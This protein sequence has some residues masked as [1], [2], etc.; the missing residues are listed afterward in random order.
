MEEKWGVKT[1]KRFQRADWSR[2]PLTEDQL[3]YASLDTHYLLPLRD[4]LLAELKSKERVE[5]AREEFARLAQSDGAAQ[6]F[7]QDGFWRI[8][9][10]RDLAPREIAVLRELYLYRDQAAR[11]ADRPPFKVLGDNALLA[12]AQTQPRRARDMRGLP[13]MTDS[14]VRRHGDGLLEAVQRGQSAVPPRRPKTP[15][16]DEA[17]LQRYETLRNWRKKRAQARGVESDVILPREALWA[18]ARRN[19]RS[20]EDLQIIA[21]LGP[22]RRQ[23]Y[24][25]EILNLLAEG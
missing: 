9:G 3:R 14:Q 25:H 19:P 23:T 12:L 4:L 1:N 21:E 24:G 7:D 15:R 20:P 5:E 8:S 10:A 16:T 22:W 11:S 13:G 6:T 18:I 17:V 2:R